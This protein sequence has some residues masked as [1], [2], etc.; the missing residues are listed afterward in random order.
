M[1]NKMNFMIL[2]LLIL[3]TSTFAYRL[4]NDD[5]SIEATNNDHSEEKVDLED[6]EAY[7]QLLARKLTI[8]TNY[9]KS[10]HDLSTLEE[11]RGHIWK[12]NTAEAERSVKTEKK[13]IDK[14]NTWEI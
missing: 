3:S 12:R 5:G 14:K 2:A 13:W 6:L 4:S 10:H 8:L 7:R 1:S 9:M 11:K